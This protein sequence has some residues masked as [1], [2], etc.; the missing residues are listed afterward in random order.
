MPRLS[1]LK[2]LRLEKLAKAREASVRARQ[3]R[4]LGLLEDPAALDDDQEAEEHIIALPNNPAFL[5][6]GDT[7]GAAS[8]LG[9][10][11]HPAP[12]AAHPLHALGHVVEGG[13]LSLGA[14]NTSDS[15]GRRVIEVFPNAPIPYGAANEALK[16]LEL[17]LQPHRADGATGKEL[18]MDQFAYR[19]L[20]MMVTCLHLYCEFQ[21]DWTLTYASQVATIS[22]GSSVWQGRETRQH[23]RAFISTGALPENPYGG[24][25]T[26][27]VDDEEL[28]SE[29]RL[30][31]QSRGNEMKAKDIVTHLEDPEV[32]AR[33]KLEEPPCLRTAQ[34]W[35]QQNMLGFDNR[36]APPVALPEDI[37][38]IS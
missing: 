2:L 27:M 20:T 30:H 28:A 18:K 1:K 26:S 11:P 31:L 7:S 19:R 5:S 10:E 8:D 29:L 4:A 16:K 33:F 13:N 23:I 22:A 15:N 3:L 17:M 9:V 6:K 24:W 25:N 14:V 32:R 21:P 12:E 36:T 35:L 37:D 38:E 34:R